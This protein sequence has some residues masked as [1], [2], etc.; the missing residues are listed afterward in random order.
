MRDG[1]QVL[2][3]CIEVEQSRIACAL[4]AKR[5]AD[6]HSQHGLI[7]IGPYRGAL[8]AREC[9]LRKVPWV[10]RR[11]RRWNAHKH[12]GIFRAREVYRASKQRME[13]SVRLCGVRRHDV[14]TA[15]K[16]RR[17]MLDA[18]PKN[19]IVQPFVNPLLLRKRAQTAAKCIA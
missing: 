3:L 17:R 5:F 8:T 13:R 1:A 12:R 6:A 19:T 2:K 9:A 14:P 4:E 18:R 15:E 7:G 16:D 10:L 11:T